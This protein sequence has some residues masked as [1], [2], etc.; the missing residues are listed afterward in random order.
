MA[1]RS[2]A[3]KHGTRRKYQTLMRGLSAPQKRPAR[4]MVGMSGPPAP[5]GREPWWQAFLTPANTRKEGD[6]GSLGRF[7]LCGGKF[8]CPGCYNTLPFGQEG[9][10]RPPFLVCSVRGSC[11]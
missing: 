5:W 6:G 8:L 7:F 4:L 9:P 1:A 10:H 2:A 11:P 3:T